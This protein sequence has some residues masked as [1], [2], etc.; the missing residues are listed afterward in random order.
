M[1]YQLCS[2]AKRIETTGPGAISPFDPF[3]EEIYKSIGLLNIE[4][5]NLKDVLR[6]YQ[7]P[8]EQGYLSFAHRMNGSTS[9]SSMATTVSISRW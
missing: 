8:S 9:A 1:E 7:N 2:F 4:R 6:F 3:E 5:A